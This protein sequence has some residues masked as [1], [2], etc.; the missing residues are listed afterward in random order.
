MAMDDDPLTARRASSDRER[1]ERAHQTRERLD[2]MLRAYWAFL[3][4]ESGSLAEAMLERA[5]K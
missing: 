5:L 2:K 4:A 1:L 3:I